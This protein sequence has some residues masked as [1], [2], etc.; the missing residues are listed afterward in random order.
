MKRIHSVFMLL[1][2]VL[3]A[4]GGGGE[5]AVSTSLS[6]GVSTPT[7]IPTPTTKPAPTPIIFSKTD[8]DWA[9]V[10]NFT[11]QLQRPNAQRIGKTAFDLVVVSI[12]AAGS[13]PETIPALKQSE[14]GD[15]LILCY[16]SIGE[17]EDYRWYWQSEWK[18]NPPAWL[19]EP[20]PVWAGDY[21]VRYWM[22]EWQEIIYGTPESYLDQIIAL[23]F[24]GV[25]MDIVD[26]YQFY[27]E[28]DGRTT[29][30]REMADF[31]IAIAEYARERHPGFG[32]F[33]Q[34]A[35][36]LG[37]LF[38]DYLETVTGMGVEDLYYGYPR[39]HE[40]SPADWTAAREATLD[41]WIAADK[42]VLTID[43]SAKADQIA[44]AYQRALVRGYVPYVTDRSL[45]RLRVNPGFEPEK[46]HAEYD[47]SAV[48][49]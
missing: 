34:N 37:I 17:A 11:Y 20:N 19:D 38:P 4:C 43:Y 16:M 21:K 28:R 33:P 23:G 5:T 49:E 12:S 6:A 13:S 42:L 7:A 22:P 39:D 30:A 36:E 1:V 10:E 40:P 14:G 46:T 41:Q 27:E 32:I 26:G 2:A 18:E 48:N 3:V 35:E 24:D 15:K 47:F 45:G 25:Y 29:A 9:T 8:E 31:V 44:D